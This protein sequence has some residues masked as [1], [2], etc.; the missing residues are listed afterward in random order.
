MKIKLL[1]LISLLAGIGAR[2][3]AQDSA[4]VVKTFLELL[5]VC[6]SVDFADPKVQETGPFYKAA[7]YI[8]YQG[9]DA[10]RKWKDIA[11]YKNANERE[12]VDDICFGINGSVNRD[13]NYTITGYRTNTESEGEWHVVHV[14]Y[15]KKDRKRNI[16]F[17]FLKIGD[18]YALGD[19]D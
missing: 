10:K 15:T 11:N 18:R 1:L 13:P 6:K 4:A 9:D 8:V 7:P 17:A 2:S 12:Q 19:I 5:A 3:K 14:S 16:S